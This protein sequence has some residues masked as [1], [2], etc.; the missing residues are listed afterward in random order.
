[1]AGALAEE[2]AAV[3][4]RMVNAKVD[5]ARGRLAVAHH[6]HRCCRRVDDA[7]ALNGTTK[8]WPIHLGKTKKMSSQSRAIR[9]SRSSASDYVVRYYESCSMLKRQ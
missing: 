5:L 4:D 9:Q 3:R 2:R 7:P 1:M 8:S 6:L